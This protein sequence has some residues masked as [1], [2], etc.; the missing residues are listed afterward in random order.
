V[1]A[2]SRREGAQETNERF[3]NGGEVKGHGSSPSKT[4]QQE[5]GADP[6]TSKGNRRHQEKTLVPAWRIFE[7]AWPGVRDRGNALRQR[8]EWNGRKVP[9]DTNWYGPLLCRQK[10]ADEST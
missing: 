4:A 10:N 7:E 9:E 6:K 5:S 8:V 3:K 1:W 2:V